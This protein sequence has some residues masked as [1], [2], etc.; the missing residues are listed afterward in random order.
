[1]FNT[2]TQTEIERQRKY[3]QNQEEV[4]VRIVFLN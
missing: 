1:M 3:Q 2:Y 4:F